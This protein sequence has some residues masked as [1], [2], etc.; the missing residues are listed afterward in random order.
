[1]LAITTI[2]EDLITY[3][4]HRGLQLSHDS[5]KDNLGLPA[6]SP[7]E[8]WL[9]IPR[10]KIIE[11]RSVRGHV[12]P[13]LL[14]GHEHHVNS[15]F[16]PESPASSQVQVKTIRFGYE[17]ENASGNASIPLRECYFS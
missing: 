16:S 15:I 9:A 3:D 8:E 12:K 10:A 5:L 13:I 11:V 14:T 2:N 6:F 17:A 4:V 7:D 1:M